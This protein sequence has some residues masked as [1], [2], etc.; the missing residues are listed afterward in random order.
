MRIIATNDLLLKY[1]L[2]AS[3]IC[4][5]CNMHVETAK[6]LFWECRHTQH[7]WNELSKYL[8]TK[9]MELNLSYEVISFGITALNKNPNIKIKNYILLC[10]KYFMIFYILK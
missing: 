3:N 10:A 1:N 5:F 4:D 9:H 2:K 8:K 6:H 7:F